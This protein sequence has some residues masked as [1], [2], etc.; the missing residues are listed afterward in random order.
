MKAEPKQVHVSKEYAHGA[1]LINCRFDPKGQHI[2]ATAEDR[3]IIRWTLADGKK[4]EFKAHDSWV[5][6]LAFSLNG[7]DT[8]NR[9]IRR[10]ARVVAC[11][12]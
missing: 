3:T 9:W 1:P 8:G 12:R 11:Q 2:F 7:V 6:G 10:H 5:R 4:A